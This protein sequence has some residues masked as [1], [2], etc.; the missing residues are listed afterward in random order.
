M[1]YLFFMHKFSKQFFTF[2]SFDRKLKNGN[3]KKKK[4]Y[5]L[6]RT[7]IWYRIFRHLSFKH[8]IV[9]SYSE[10]RKMIYYT[11]AS[12]KISPIFFYYELIKSFSCISMWNNKH[13]IK[14]CTTQLIQLAF[15]VFKSF[16]LNYYAPKES[17]SQYVHFLFVFC[18]FIPLFRIFCSSFS[19]LYLVFS[20]F[21]HV[22]VVFF[23]FL[24]TYVS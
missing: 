2:L 1:T 14:Y 9:L 17:I 7:L 5:K 6:Y 11:V 19:F 18:S 16:Q 15:V 13:I 20:L 24:S 3:E 22:V 10:K 8:F 23:C 21:D 12:T 4:N